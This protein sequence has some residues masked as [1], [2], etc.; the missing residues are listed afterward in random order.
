MYRLIFS[1]ILVIFFVSTVQAGN[2]DEISAIKKTAMDYMESWYQGDTKRM[3]G[4][5]HPDLAKRSLKFKNGKLRLRHTKSRDMKYWTGVGYG[6]NLWC[7]THNIE[8]FVLDHY[9]GISSV[10]V[11]TP[12]YWEYLHLL[13]I[14]GKWL[15]I[16]AL[17]EDK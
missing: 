4:S 11:V 12:D 13:K 9:K 15:I 14:E 1:I 17:Y 7:D 6:K 10:K 16:N 3:D 8:I 5:L 2:N